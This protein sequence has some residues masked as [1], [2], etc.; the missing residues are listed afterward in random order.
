DD[1]IAFR[2]AAPG[3]GFSRRLYGAIDP[4]WA[5]ILAE[6][7]VGEGYFTQPLRDALGL[8]N[9]VEVGD[10]PDPV[11][12]LGQRGD[13]MRMAVAERGDGDAGTKVEI[14]LAVRR[15]KPC[16]FAPLESEVNA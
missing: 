14:A 6:H 1:A 2:L 8:R 9:F 11:G 12:L 16:A 13:E 3:L 15:R 10:V 7:H 4:P 5:R